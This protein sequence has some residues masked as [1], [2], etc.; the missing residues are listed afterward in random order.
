M[1]QYFNNF[2]KIFKQKINSPLNR[3]HLKHNC[4]FTVQQ[5][6]STYK[7]RKKLTEIIKLIHLSLDRPT[8]LDIQT[9]QSDQTS[10]L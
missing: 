6:T 2:I 3:Y 7:F 5:A 1:K 8:R 9:Y 4:S 10:L